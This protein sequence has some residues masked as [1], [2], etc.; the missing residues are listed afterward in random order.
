MEVVLE[1]LVKGHNLEDKEYIYYY[2]LIESD[3][4]LSWKQEDIKVQSYGIEITRKD[5]QNEQFIK[6][7]NNN[8]RHI[9]PHRYKVHNLLKMLYEQTVSPIHLIDVIGAYTDEYVVDY[10]NV[11]K[12]VANVS[13]VCK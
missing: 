11:F 10:E 7:E 13:A 2:K 12:N 6:V 3:L 5:F 8:I 4:N 9:S 1:N